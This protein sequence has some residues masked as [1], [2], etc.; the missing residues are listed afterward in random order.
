MGRSG[1]GM[2]FNLRRARGKGFHVIA[3][4]VSV[5]CEGPRGRAVVMAGFGHGSLE[6]VATYDDPAQLCLM[7][8]VDADYVLGTHDEEI[9]RLGLQ[10]RVWRP[11][12]LAGWQRA[13]FTSGMTI[14]DV[15]CGPG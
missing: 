13:G 9:E 2:R 5:I 10:H 12:V 6:P 3:R 15:G 8:N 4:T 11:R 14:A 1:R 7:S